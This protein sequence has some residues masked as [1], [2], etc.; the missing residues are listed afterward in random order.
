MDRLAICLWYPL[1]LLA[2]QLR[3]QDRLVEVELQEADTQ[4]DHLEEVTTM[5]QISPHMDDDRTQDRREGVLQAVTAQEETQVEA[6]QE[7]REAEDLQTNPQTEVG[8]PEET[9]PQAAEV[10]EMVAMTVADRQL[11]KLQSCQRLTSRS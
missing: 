5:A 6:I 7:G 3:L 9:D 1:L 4:V 8:R 10:M 11:M 2:V